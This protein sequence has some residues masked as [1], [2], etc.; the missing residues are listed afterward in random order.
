MNIVDGK[1]GVWISCSMT[2]LLIIKCAFDIASCLGV[3]ALLLQFLCREV[4]VVAVM[5]VEQKFHSHRWGK[6]SA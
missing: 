3:H 2:A 6:G 1:R 4:K 5:S